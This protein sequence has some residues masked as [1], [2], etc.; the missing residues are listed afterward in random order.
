MSQKNEDI[1]EEKTI[2]SLDTQIKELR[3]KRAEI[4]NN[5]PKE[6]INGGKL[7]NGLCNFWNPVLWLKDITSVFNIRKIIIFT[8]IFSLIFGFGYMKAWKNKPILVN[9]K[10][11]IIET[12]IQ[13]GIERGDI[14]RIEAQNG[15][16]FYQ[17]IRKNGINSPKYPITNK[18]L[19]KLKPYGI[20]L[21]PKIFLGFGTQGP[22]VGAGFEIAHFWRLNLDVFG[23]SD[24][25]VYVGI[26][27]DIDTKTDGPF[28]NSTV[29]IAMG[30]SLENTVETRILVYWS[31]K[32]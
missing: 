23:M 10:N 20:K 26:S 14:L 8:I 22:A 19:P 15:K 17:F 9:A 7:A 27:Y 28:A 30:K 3:K 12:T 18:D 25:A 32:F 11:F 4:A 13:Q 2:K 1:N 21:K 29:G 5:T 24:K 6:Q 16:M 31:V